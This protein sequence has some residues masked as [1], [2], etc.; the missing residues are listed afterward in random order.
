[1]AALS[2]EAVADLAERLDEAQIEGRAI[3][4]ISDAHPHMD[5]Q[6][7]YAVQWAIRQRKLARGR[8]LAGLK[9][10]LTSPAKMKQLGVDTPFYAFLADDTAVADGG[11]VDTASLIHPQVEAE[12]AVVTNR[13]L[14]G[15]GCHIG[16][17][18][19]AIEWV[20]PAIEVIDS[21]YQDSRFDLPSAIADNGLAA[22]FAVGGNAC[23]LPGLD[24]KTL[25]AV[26]E[27][28]GEVAQV[29]AGAAVLGHPLASV[30]M[31]ANLLADREQAIPAG[32]LI[33]TGSIIEAVAVG[34][35]DAV[36][37][38][39]QNLGAVSLRFS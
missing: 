25:G 29:G 24:L 37:A 22:R 28:N 5:Q 23:R 32:T 4:R 13:P 33:L 35:G 10:G 38:R 3:A 27:K 1:M 8:G 16:Q 18:A 19:A 21:R 30:A 20:L 26:L 11:E 12:I 17:A 9:M 15:P 39:F 2:L 31:L 34:P 36:Q 6:D 14:R 7:A